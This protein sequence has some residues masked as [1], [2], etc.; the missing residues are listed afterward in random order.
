MNRKKIYIISGVLII[1]IILSLSIYFYFYKKS[2]QG[3]SE[4]QK[5][6][7]LDQLSKESP[8]NV[9]VQQKTDILK[10]LTTSSNKSGSVGGLTPAQKLQMMQSGGQ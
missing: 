4:Q 7:L 5:I 10:D 3:L 9:T 8:N 6:D 1:L 2:T